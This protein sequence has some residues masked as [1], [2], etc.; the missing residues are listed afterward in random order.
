MPPPSTQRLTEPYVNH[1]DL[2]ILYDLYDVNTRQNKGKKSRRFQLRNENDYKEAKLGSRGCYCCLKGQKSSLLNSTEVPPSSH[3]KIIYA[4]A[5]IRMVNRSL[6]THSHS[7]G[8]RGIRLM[9]DNSGQWSGNVQGQCGKF[10]IGQPAERRLLL[11]DV[12]KFR[13]A[14]FVGDI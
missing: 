5:Y 11:M 3:K 1:R 10:S 13:P 8:R 7:L 2:I 6:F 4:L 12:N 9:G 14:S